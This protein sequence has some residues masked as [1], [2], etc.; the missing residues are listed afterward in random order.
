[1]GS[2]SISSS[3]NE[4]FPSKESLQTFWRSELHPLDSHRSTEEIPKTCDVL[5]IGAGYAGSST[6]YHLLCNDDV[7][8]MSPKPSV[9]LLEAR[10][11]C[12]GATAR[13]G[14]YIL[15]QSKSN[16]ESRL[17]NLLGG[18]LRPSIFGRLP[19]YLKEYGI[20]TVLELVD[21]ENDHVEAIAAL[22][23]REKIDCDFTRTKSV[24]AYVTPNDAV[25]AKK[26]YL[27]LK[28]A[29]L[30]KAIIQ[31]TKWYDGEE[32]EK[33]RETESIIPSMIPRFIT[34]HNSPRSQVSKE[35]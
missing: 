9:L 8:K 25:M 15:I 6:A 33:V 27:K 32:A 3:N 5:I 23:E 34:S 31:N 26:A 2:L 21:F 24:N 20:D 17:R 16:V 12:S 14:L 10:Q 13:N 19:R 22:V 4:I 29:G 18:H 7:P 11:A 28:K 1:M 30:N 35:L